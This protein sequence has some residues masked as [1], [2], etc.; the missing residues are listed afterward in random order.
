[1]SRINRELLLRGLSSPSSS[2]LDLHLDRYA[3]TLGFWI[4]RHLLHPFNHGLLTFN[5]H[6]AA[7]A[8]DGTCD[9][10]L[11]Q[12][13]HSGFT[14]CSALKRPRWT[15]AL[16]GLPARSSMRKSL[17]SMV[18]PPLAFSIPT[19]FGSIYPPSTPLETL[20]SK[21]LSSSRRTTGVSF[22]N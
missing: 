10:L 1:M 9:L 2:A 20:V 15:E 17:W 18:C 5:M 3:G 12:L 4:V 22:T 19:L 6:R 21:A 7:R 11:S 13:I 14:S 8:S 16:R